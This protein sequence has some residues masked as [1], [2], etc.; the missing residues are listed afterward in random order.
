MIIDI[1]AI[2]FIVVLSFILCM[3]TNYKCQLSYIV[4]GLSVIVFY[5]LAAYFKLNQLINSQKNTLSSSSTLGL[6]ITENFGSDS[7]TASINDF[8]SGNAVGNSV[9]SPSQ[10]QGLTATELAAY[11]QKLTDLIN[12]INSLNNQ[13][14][15]PSTNIAASPDTIQKLDLESQQQY[16][17]FQIDY[18]NK[19]IANAKDIIN[20]QSISSSSSAY[21]PIK[22]YSSC[23]ISN[24]NG[25]TSIDTPVAQSGQ[26]NFANAMNTN[27]MNANAMSSTQQ[28]LKTISQQP[29]IQSNVYTGQQGQQ[30]L[31]AN[32]YVNLSPSTGMFKKILNGISG[33]NVNVKK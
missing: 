7:V 27:A 13:Q 3:N 16:Q 25:T 1:I 18:L 30:G 32:N 5:K 17:M 20:S 8:I 14:N 2:V 15:D 6:G 26:S 19:Q 10:A 12:T 28:M 24:A 4:L 22:V 29:F 21:K 23:V 11:N 31:Q 33:G 9:L